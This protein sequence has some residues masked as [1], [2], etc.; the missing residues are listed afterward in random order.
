MARTLPYPRVKAEGVVIRASTCD[1]SFN[2]NSFYY[3]IYIFIYD[4]SGRM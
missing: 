1:H 3:F 2:N 4:R